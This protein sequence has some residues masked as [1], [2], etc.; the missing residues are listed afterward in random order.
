MKN[1]K[2]LLATIFL[3]T[4]FA[5]LAQDPPHDDAEHEAAESD[6]DHSHWEEAHGAGTPKE[7]GRSIK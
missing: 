2:L 5:V 3:S 4:S 6:L 1:F 7:K